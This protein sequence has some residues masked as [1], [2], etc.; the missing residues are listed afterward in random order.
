MSDMASELP[1]EKPSRPDGRHEGRPTPGAHRP[2]PRSEG[3]FALRVYKPGQGFYT[4]VGTAI[5]VGILSVW[6][7]KFI[8]DELS[9]FL[10]PNKPYY[11]P[12]RYGITVGFLAVMGFLVYWIAGLNR[13]ANDFFIAT[14]GEMKKVSWSTRKEV[15]RSTKV[16]IVTVVL[17]SAFLFLSDVMF[18]LFFNGIG[19]LKGVPGVMK[20]FGLE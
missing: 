12:V 6:G 19:V 1:S 7:S 20:V 18:M 5:G 16:V 15:T 4:R 10:N 17:L 11:L 3:G 8:F 14:E 9:A 13:K 2:A